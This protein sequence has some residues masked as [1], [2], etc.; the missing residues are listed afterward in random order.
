MF[1]QIND[2]LENGQ[3]TEIDRFDTSQLKTAGTKIFGLGIGSI[4]GIVDNTDVERGGIEVDDGVLRS[5]LIVGGF[6]N[7][8]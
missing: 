4:R 3:R 7:G 6:G 5:G 2:P 8:T 1:F